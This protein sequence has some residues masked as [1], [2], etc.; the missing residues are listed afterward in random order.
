MA[1]TIANA[2]VELARYVFLAYATKQGRD[3][4]IHWPRAEFAHEAG[5]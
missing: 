4:L 3:V 1:E 5:L 2:V